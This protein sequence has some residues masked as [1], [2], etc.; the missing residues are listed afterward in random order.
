MEQPSGDEWVKR[1]TRTIGERVAFY[2]QRVTEDGRKL[3]GQGLADR[4]ERLGLRIDR[5]AIA[6]LESGH[7]QSVSVADVQVLAAA[8]EIPPLALLMPIFTAEEAEILPGKVLPSRD[9]FK[10]FIGAESISTQVVNVRSEGDESEVSDADVVEWYDT[11]ENLVARIMRA[12]QYY[13]DMLLHPRNAAGEPVEQGSDIQQAMLKVARQDM[14]MSR[15]LLVTHR[16]W[17]RLAGLELPRLPAGVV[18]IVEQEPD[19]G[20]H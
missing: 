5:P 10:W 1:L 6:K 3:T 7:R 17:I 12:D 19:D 18:V 20:A 13:E 2:R 9:A 16:R 11:H 14:T 15:R 4:T 8:L